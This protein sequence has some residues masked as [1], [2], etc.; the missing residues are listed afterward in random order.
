MALYTL[1]NIVGKTVLVSTINSTTSSIYNVF[2]NF[3]NAHPLLKKC[4]DEFDLHHK[5]SILTIITQKLKHKYKDSECIQF[6]LHN[7]EQLHNS[8]LEL[9]SEINQDIVYHKTL[10]FYKFRKPKYII[11]I[12]TL[13]KLS[14]KIDEQ[15]NILS[16]IIIIEQ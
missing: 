5:L 16:K 12:K 14:I 3:K 9:L 15:L 4:L 10:Y 1:A 13:K 8:I 11:K 2:G 6:M 7:L